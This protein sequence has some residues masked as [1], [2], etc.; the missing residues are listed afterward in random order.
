MIPARGANLV[1]SDSF[2]LASVRQGGQRGAYPRRC[3][4][5]TLNVGSNPAAVETGTLAP[6]LTQSCTLALGI[7]AMECGDT[8]ARVSCLIYPPLIEDLGYGM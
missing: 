8:Y 1:A 3:L 2:P 6:L 5:L 7:G 4:R